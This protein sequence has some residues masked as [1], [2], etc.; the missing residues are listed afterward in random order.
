[1]PLPTRLVPVN[2][3]FEWHH[4]R[5]AELRQRRHRED[6]DVRLPMMYLPMARKGHSGYAN[7]PVR[8][9]A[10]ATIGSAEIAAGTASSTVVVRKVVAPRTVTDDETPYRDPGDAFILAFVSSGQVRPGFGHANTEVNAGFMSMN[11]MS[12]VSGFHVTPDFRSMSVRI[13]KEALGLRGAEAEKLSRVMTPYTDGTPLV[14]CAIATQVLA[15]RS[16]L[17]RAASEIVARSL[18]DLAVAYANETLGRLSSPD[19]VRRN[20]VIEAKRHI[21]ANL[22]DPALTPATIADAMHISLR[23]L[24]LAFEDEAASVA[25]TILTRR[26]ERCRDALDNPALRYLTIE[27][28]AAKWG[29]ASASHFSRAFRSRYG[30]SPRDW[31][32][33]EAATAVLA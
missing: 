14:L 8:V 22:V 21:E 27:A 30:C 3:R 4:N 31:R 11:D 10:S 12:R 24:H 5:D 25:R 32:M 7:V 18:T 2:Q 15:M 20:V 23:S 19:L 17:E 1:M 16:T 26:L 33:R 6:Y 28:I 13:D 9:S 29:F